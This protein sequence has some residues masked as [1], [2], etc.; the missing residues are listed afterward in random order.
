M[1][2]IPEIKSLDD[3]VDERAKTIAKEYKLDVKEIVPNYWELKSIIE[4]KLFNKINLD[5]DDPD[6]PLT[7]YDFYKRIF[8]CGLVI[9]YEFTKRKRLIFPISE[10]PTGLV[11]INNNTLIL[12][13]SKGKDVLYGKA[14]VQAYEQLGK[15][16]QKIINNLDELRRRSLSIK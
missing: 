1:K 5:P 14:S 8:A 6:V 3:L 13:T 11:F 4:H 16:Y 10:K 12:R 7:I 2:N 15:Y 9:V